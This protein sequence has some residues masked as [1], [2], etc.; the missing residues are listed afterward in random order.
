MGKLIC[1]EAT[2]R[3]I[4][5]ELRHAIITANVSKATAFYSRKTNAISWTSVIH[6]GRI[7]SVLQSLA[8]HTGS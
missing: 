7:S 4:A 6:K 3:S 8:L 2:V 1:P 5:F